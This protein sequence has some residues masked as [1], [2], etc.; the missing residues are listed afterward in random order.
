MIIQNL[1]TP[2]PSIFIERR[3]SLTVGKLL[4]GEGGSPCSR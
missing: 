2:T 3:D 1:T 4:T